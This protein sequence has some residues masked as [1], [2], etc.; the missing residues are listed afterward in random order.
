MG[1]TRVTPG[2]LPNFLALRATTR[3]LDE[4]TA[5]RPDGR[6]AARIQHRQAIVV[7]AWSLAAEHGS[8]G[9]TVEAVA[10]RAGVSRRTV[11]NHFPSLD[12]IRVAVGEDVLV[13]VVDA[14]LAAIALHVAA[15]DGPL[16]SLDAVVDAVRQ[17]DLPAAIVA[18][19][20]VFGELDDGGER[21]VLSEATFDR[22]GQRVLAQVAASAPEL[23]PLD[24]ELVV[25]FLTNG[26]AVVARHWVHDHAGRLDDASRSAWETRLDRLLAQ[27]RAAYRAV[28]LHHA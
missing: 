7:A 6:S 13:D 25:A 22:V 27:V 10:A 19:A 3:T 11:F 18:L 8:H 14:F 17:P 21:F 28:P 12:A 5:P 26:L 1:E 4:V 16:A 20:G 24:V 15:A 23:D 2:R 9:F